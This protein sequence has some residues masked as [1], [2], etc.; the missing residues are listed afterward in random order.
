MAPRFYSITSSPEARAGR[1]EICVLEVR[2]GKDNKRAGLSSSYLAR[3]GGQTI[4]ML[5]RHGKFKYPSDVTSPIIMV[6]LGIGIAAMLP[7][8]S[9]RVS[10]TAKLGPCFLILSTRFMGSFPYLVKY[11]QSLADSKVITHFVQIASRDG[12]R[13]M[14]VQQYM[15][16]N[17]EKLWEYWEDYRTG[18]YYCGPKKDIPEQLEQIMLDITIHE[19]W[20][21]MEEAMAVNKRHPWYIEAS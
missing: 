2:F 17:S 10:S 7:L 1:L 19:G 14:H 13:P 20:L 18:F 16:A 4:A 21:S 15:K 9:V 3:R 6:A 5:T 12:P 8:L 11:I